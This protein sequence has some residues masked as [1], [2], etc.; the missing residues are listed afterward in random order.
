MFSN[1]FW[2]LNSLLAIMLDYRFWVKSILIYHGSDNQ[3]NFPVEIERF[4]EMISKLHDLFIVLFWLEPIVLFID[5]FAHL[6]LNLSPALSEPSSD[7]HLFSKPWL[8]A[9]VGILWLF[10]SLLFCGLRLLFFWL[11]LRLYDRMNRFRLWDNTRI[12]IYG[13]LVKW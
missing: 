12:F 3:F 5:P 11:I 2:L 4:S 9:I 1:L 10:S 13:N 6:S 8:R 7:Y